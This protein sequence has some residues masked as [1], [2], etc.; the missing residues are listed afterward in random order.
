MHIIQITSDKNESLKSWRKLQRSR[1]ER[2]RMGQLLIEGEHLLTEARAHQCSFHAVLLD[3]GQARHVPAW[4][5]WIE[6]QNIPVYSLRSTLYRDLMDTETP[7]GVAAVI[8][9][10]RSRPFHIDNAH[11]LVL[12]LD[13]IQDPG[14]LGTI[15]RT[16]A[17]GGV[18]F[19]GLGKGTVD[20]F[21]PKVVRSASGALFHVPFATIDLA[22]WI[23]RYQAVGGS[24]FGTAAG[25]DEDHYDVTYP[26][27]TAFLL[28]N[29]GQGLSPALMNMTDKIVRIPMPGYAESLNVA[30]ASA[31]LLYEVIR[32]RQG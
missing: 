1:K 6:E 26:D 8:D 28:G 15:L 4:L 25:A 16:A 10:P 23:L 22:D 11:S 20:P 2:S 32:Q 18:S 31:V 30:I 29:E 21:N 14:N 27:R 7:Q 13:Q 12:L 5:N 19:V 24:V 17:A 9:L 3:E